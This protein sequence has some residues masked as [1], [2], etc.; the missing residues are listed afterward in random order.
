[1][2]K[3]PYCPDCGFRMIE[4]YETATSTT[5]HCLGCGGD[6]TVRKTQ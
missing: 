4:I 2:A 3:D 1:M 5:Y 6:T